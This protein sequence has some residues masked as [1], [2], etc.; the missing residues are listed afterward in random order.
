MKYYINRTN[1]ALAGIDSLFNDI[2]GDNY[3]SSRV[4]AVDVYETLENYVVEAEVAGYEEKDISVSVEK[5]VLTV[6]SNDKELKKVN[7]EESKEEKKEERNYLIREISKPSFSRSF[8]LPEDVDED[9]ISAETKSG[10]L[11]I[12]LPKTAKAQRGRI[13]VKIN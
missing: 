8:T 4:P 10:V 1:P 9:N 7:Q 13:E 3:Y 5:H 2:F 6:S 11:R 12:V